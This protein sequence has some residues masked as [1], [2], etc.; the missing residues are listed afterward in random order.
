MHDQDNNFGKN[1]YMP[2]IESLY[3][4]NQTNILFLVSCPFASP[5]PPYIYMELSGDGAVPLGIINQNVIYL[6]QMVFPR[7]TRG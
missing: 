4:L 3:M 5:P 6:G 1:N 7:V 2:W